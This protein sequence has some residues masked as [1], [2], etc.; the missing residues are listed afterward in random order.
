MDAQQTVWNKLRRDMGIAFI[1]IAHDLPV[2]RDFI[3]QNEATG[4]V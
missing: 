3:A 4:G 2:V 1:F